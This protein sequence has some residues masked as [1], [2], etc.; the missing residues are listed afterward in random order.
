MLSLVKDYHLNILLDQLKP[1]LS[2][3]YQLSYEVG[4]LYFMK[5]ALP[6]PFPLPRF[7]AY[8]YVKL[9]MV[10]IYREGS[11]H[12]KQV[13]SNKISSRLIYFLSPIKDYYKYTI[14]IVKTMKR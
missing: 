10:C 4:H 8:R 12:G 11:L 6:S 5:A 2:F 1:F 7:N 3:I 9:D 13:L 14:H